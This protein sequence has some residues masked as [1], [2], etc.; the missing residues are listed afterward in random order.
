MLAPASSSDRKQMEDGKDIEFRVNTPEL[1][2]K[3]H[4]REQLSQ[5][6]ESG[7]EQRWQ[8]PTQP[9]RVH[10]LVP[11]VGPGSKAFAAAA[12]KA[13]AGPG[14]SLRSFGPAI[15]VCLLALLAARTKVLSPRGLLVVLAVAVL[16]SLSRYKKAKQAAVARAKK[17]EAAAAAAAKAAAGPDPRGPRT[18]MF[19]YGTLKRGFHWNHKFLSAAK[20]LGYAETVDKF[21]MV[22]GTS[23]VVRNTTP[24]T[25]CSPFNAPPVMMC[26]L[27]RVLTAVSAR[28]P[29]RLELRARQGLQAHRG[30]AVGSGPCDAAGSR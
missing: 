3:R 9:V 14:L 29:G 17:S 30:R 28:R 26:C 4:S 24:C 10:E 11:A 16:A 18:L 8:T 25:C 5:L 23:G 15:F 13:R 27:H 20:C 19:F 6:I 21:P 22:V 12:A 7:W 1:Q 2:Q